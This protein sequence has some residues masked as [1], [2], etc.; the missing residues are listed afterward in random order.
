[1]AHEELI[2][3]PSLYLLAQVIDSEGE[4]DVE[5]VLHA[6]AYKYETTYSGNV[7]SRVFLNNVVAMALQREGHIAHKSDLYWQIDIEGIVEVH[8]DYWQINYEANGQTYKHSYMPTAVLYVNGRAVNEDSRP[9]NDHHVSRFI[10]DCETMFSRSTFQPISFH[11]IFQI[12]WERLSKG[13]KA[14]ARTQMLYCAQLLMS[15]D[16]GDIEPMSTEYGKAITEKARWIAMRWFDYLW[17]MDESNKLVDHILSLQSFIVRNQDAW[18][19]GLDMHLPQLKIYTAEHEEIK[20]LFCNEPET[21]Y[22]MSCKSI[23]LALWKKTGIITG[24]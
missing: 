24:K 20:K 19:S 21:D 13:N 23:I 8:R 11:D 16:Y 15:R 9:W 2:A 4:Q 22:V 6:I 18:L 3:H 17:E 1:M 7:N 5:T 14:Q 12:A 10:A